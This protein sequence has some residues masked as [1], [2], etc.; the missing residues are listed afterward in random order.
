MRFYPNLKIYSKNNLY[1]KSIK[2]SINSKKMSFGLKCRELENNLKKKLNVKNVILTTNGTSALMMAALASGIKKGDLVYCSNAAWVAATNPF[3][4][5]GAEIKL[6]DTK[7]NSEIIDFNELNKKI[8]NRPPKLVILVHLNGQPNYNSEFE[9]LKKKYKFFVIEDAAQALLS[10][11]KNKSC[12]TK[13]DIGCFSLSIAKPIHMIYGGFCCTN[14][15]NIAERLKAARNNGVFPSNESTALSTTTG[16][17]FKPSDLHAAIGLENL[18]DFSR[19]K[20]ILIQNMKIYENELKNKNIKFLK[21][22]G[23]DSVP[24]FAH[25]LVKNKQKFF[26]FCKEF[27]IGTTPGLRGILESKNYSIKNKK[28]FKNSNLLSKR[29]VRIPFG[30]GY[31]PE[32]IKKIAIILNRY[33]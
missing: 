27:N 28:H 25:V 11:Y 18:R 1:I 7:K 33:K 13:F 29:I 26:K 23:K 21:P 10:K 16:L 24:N 2:N 9:F 3:L 17:N 5:I 31:K 15:K 8:R 6:I 32:E 14:K 19:I 20:K 12:G 22:E 30:A 4:I